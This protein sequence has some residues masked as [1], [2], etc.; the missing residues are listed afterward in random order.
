MILHI[1]HS[2]REL[3][4]HIELNREQENLGYLTDTDTDILFDGTFIRFPL[5]RFVC[6][7]ERLRVNEPMDGQGQG[8]IYRKDCYG[9]SII[10]HT[11]DEEIYKMYDDHHRKLT[12]EINHQLAY[13]ENVVIVDCHSFPSGASGVSDYAF[14]LE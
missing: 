11:S 5:S 4:G 8:I 6:D 2:S 7:V 3:G 13:F 10:R 1:P 9:D 14:C 12:L